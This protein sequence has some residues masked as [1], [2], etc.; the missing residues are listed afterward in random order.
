MKSSLPNSFRRK[1][2]EAADA[3][4]AY[5]A[6]SGIVKKSPRSVQWI[7]KFVDTL[8]NRGSDQVRII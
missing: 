7:I 8:R 5:G 2:E 4:R 3:T 1:V 6:Q